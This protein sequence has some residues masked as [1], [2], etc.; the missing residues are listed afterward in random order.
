VAISSAIQGEG[1]TTILANLAVSLAQAQH[2]TLIIDAD[3]RLAG[4]SRLFQ[5]TEQTHPAG[6]SDLLTG[7]RSLEESISPTLVPHL[8]I[9][10]AG[11]TAPNPAELVGSASMKRLLHGLRDRY[12]FILV[13]TPPIMAVADAL[14]ISRVVDSVLLV[15]RHGFT[16][17][18]VAREARLKLSRVKARVLGLVLNVVPESSIH[19]S[20]LLYGANYLQVINE[21]ENPAA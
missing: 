5:S 18:S 4:L 16:P 1:K 15:V 17:R 2:R 9:L 21:S 6:L 7:Q 10:P 8:D 19:K 14:L 20:G 11:S 12:D 3:L 13:D